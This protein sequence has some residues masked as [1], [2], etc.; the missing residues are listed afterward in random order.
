MRGIE[1]QGILKYKRGILKSRGE[2][3]DEVGVGERE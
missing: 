3:Y 2:N 1:K